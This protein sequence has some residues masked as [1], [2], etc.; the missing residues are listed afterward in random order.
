MNR[1]LRLNSFTAHQTILRS[2]IVLRKYILLSL[3]IVISLLTATA[4]HA[5]VIVETFEEFAAGG[6]TQIP[7]TS[8]TFSYSV[9]ASSATIPISGTSSETYSSS[10]YTTKGATGAL[11]NTNRSTS[12]TGCTFTLAST[13]SIT[14]SSVTL[15]PG[16]ASTFTWYYGASSNP[17]RIKITSNTSIKIHS[18]DYYAEIPT[19]SLI[20]SPIVP[21]GISMVTFWVYGSSGAGAGNID[22]G[23]RTTQ[24]LTANNYAT[25]PSNCTGGTNVFSSQTSSFTNTGPTY[26]FGKATASSISTVRYTAA[27]SVS[28]L[29]TTA[30]GSTVCTS[31]QSLF[32]YTFTVPASLQ[33]SPGQ[34]AI[35][36]D[37]NTIYID[38]IEIFAAGTGGGPAIWTGGTSAVWS[39]TGN[40]LYGVVP[41]STTDAFI[42]VTGTQP[43]LSGAGAVRNLSLSPSTTLTLNGNTLTINGAIT[44][45]GT[46]S[47][48][49]TS[50]LSF[51]TS[52]AGT[53]YFTSGS[54][55][56]QNLTLSDGANISIG[57]PLN[58]ASTGVVTVGSITGA[59]LASGGNLTLISDNSGSARI[60]AVPVSG[61]ISQSTI[62]GIVNVECYIHSSNSAIPGAHRAWRL[63]TAPITNSG[64]TPATTIN[65]SWQNENIYSPGIGTMITAPPN[66]ANPPI[67]GLDYGI[68]GNYSA[69]TWDVPSQSLVAVTNTLLANISGAN[70]SAD[71]IGYFIFIRG[72][73]DP[74]TVTVPSFAT[75]N[76]TTLSSSGALQLGDQTFSYTSPSVNGLALIGNPYASP[77]DF[78]ILAGDNVTN[79]TSYLSNLNNRFYLWDADLSGSSGQGGYICMDGTANDFN[80]VNNITSTDISTDPNIQIQSGQAIFVQSTTSGPASITFKENAKSATNNFIYRPESGGFS[81]TTGESFQAT[82]SLLNADNSTTLTDGIVAQ[83]KNGYS[84]NIDYLDALKFRNIDEMFSLARHGK[85]LC[86][87]RRPEIGSADTLFLNLQQMS[88][89]NYQFKLSTAIANHPGLGAR[90]EDSYTGITTPL[91]MLGS[92][93]VNF[94]VD[95]NAGSQD[96]SRFK[97]VFGALNI[98]PIYTNIDAMRESN[99]IDVKWSLSND[100]SMTDYVLQRSTDSV[101]YTTVDSIGAAHTT[102]AYNWVDT[103]IVANTNYY[104]RVLTTNVL[105]EES[106]SSVVV[107]SIKSLDPQ[108]ILVYPNPVIGGQIKLGLNDMPAGLYKYRLV[109]TLGQEVQ[110]GSFTYGGGTG[111]A[112]VPLSSAIA[113]GTYQLELLDPD[114]TTTTISVVY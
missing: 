100:S 32:Q 19:T 54:N 55:T 8:C 37:G 10:T 110:T 94:T 13:S 26:T 51:G 44:G 17:D 56:L 16:L 104:Y 61:G 98:P 24:T 41:T 76:N 113:N 73:R 46:I 106:Y 81:T 75:Y 42:P 69:Y 102:G 52:A 49:S 20:I 101:N 99:T 25:Y 72:D 88:Q 84:D 71:N 92:N 7:K 5:Q 68:N 2:I 83:F 22:V 39:N 18:T 15:G 86:I 57:S 4:S 34:I 60:A 82:L 23:F 65:S 40:W 97:V 103:N 29:T 58:I 48:S 95:A 28:G 107:A 27:A 59:I 38:D 89:R 112:P 67:N 62:S 96:T 77:V 35:I 45:T 80:Y 53:V 64:V 78:S 90:L 108:G 66:I 79:I 36:S 63:L 91:N 114:K 109:N 12:S 3:F 105:N 74:N 9:A 47:G 70:G 30:F 85:Q 6:T 33:G 31:T 21:Q 87:E 93:T 1:P 50:S 111:T 43:V 11:P 14:S